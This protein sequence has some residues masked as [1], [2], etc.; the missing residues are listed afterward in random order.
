MRYSGGLGGRL[1]AR[2][3]RPGNRL[4]GAV[5]LAHPVAMP[6]V[7]VEEQDRALEALRRP[8]QSGRLHHAYL[9]VGTPG[10][11]KGLAAQGLAEALLCE[12]PVAQRDRGDACGRCS[13]CLRA[14]GRQHPD[15]HIV[16]RRE[17]DD[18][19]LEQSIRIDQVRELQRVLALK[20]FESGRRVVIV[21]EAER[22]NPATANALLKTLEEPGEATH[23]I[24]V[25]SG[26]HLLLPTIVSRCQR[27]RFAPLPRA[28]I[29]SRIATSAEL[30][31]SDADLVAGLANGSLGQAMS[32]ANSDVLPARER[33]L[34]RMDDPSGLF[35]VDDLLSLAET[36]ASPSER[37]NLPMVFLLLRAWFRD[38]L[39]AH[40]GMPD[41]AFVHR[42]LADAV[43]R[44]ADELT[45]DEILARLDRINEAELGIE[46]ASANP[47]LVLEAMLL[48]F[49]GARRP[50]QAA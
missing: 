39:L 18:G 15:L 14:A 5:A 8:L 17:K 23:F 42:D 40:S 30:T 37:G 50:E 20:S 16:Q 47:R 4:A 2:V 24:L 29:A 49:A 46:Q 12:V 45:H 22:M 31:E 43:R 48:R 7:A 9:F 11:G 25:S 41:A 28:F 44:R 36:L 3:R 10:I 35:R 13:A 1:A 33:L 38:V 34:A 6:L 27:V 26:A 32:L 19:R 21:L